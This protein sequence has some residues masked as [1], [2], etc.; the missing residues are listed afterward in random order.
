MKTPNTMLR[1]GIQHDLELAKTV[2]FIPIILMAMFYAASFVIFAA[3]ITAPFVLLASGGVVV[4]VVS[5]I[6]LNLPGVLSI[7]V[8]L[9]YGDWVDNDYIVPGLMVWIC[10]LS[11]VLGFCVEIK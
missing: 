9:R 5:A 4:F 2:L 11:A 7:W 6:V 8:I 10:A 3:P 1:A